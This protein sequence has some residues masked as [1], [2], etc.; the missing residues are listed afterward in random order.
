MKYLS[1]I[2]LATTLIVAGCTDDGYEREPL[3][4]VGT[5]GLF[6]YTVLTDTVRAD[7]ILSGKDTGYSLCWVSQLTPI[8]S[9]HNSEDKTWTPV[10]AMLEENAK[11]DP[12]YLD[13]DRTD[14]KKYALCT[15][16]AIIRMEAK[17]FASAVRILRGR[18]KQRAE[19]REAEKDIREVLKQKK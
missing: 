17:E 4:P 10:R 13:A 8:V 6:P 19:D 11:V 7:D 18:E 14:P 15:K 9:I 2:V 1:A 16:G 3:P 5:K 12:H